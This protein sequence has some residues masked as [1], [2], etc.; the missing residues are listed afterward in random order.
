MYKDENIE[1]AKRRELMRDPAFRQKHFE[2]QFKI[3]NWRAS[4]QYAKHY[5]MKGDS[6]SDPSLCSTEFLW[7][8]L[9]EETKEIW[10]ALPE[11]YPSELADI[12]LVCDM[13]IERLMRLE[14][15]SMAGER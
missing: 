10:Q 3:A 6:W 1:V 9:K 8:K 2:N 14:N 12:I 13:L 5:P 7:D 11:N 4:M 15:V